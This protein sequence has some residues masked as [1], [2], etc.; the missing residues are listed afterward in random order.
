VSETS[1]QDA[2]TPPDIGRRTLTPFGYVLCVAVPILIAAIGITFLYFNYD[3]EDLVRGDRLQLLTSDW[4][5][6]DDAMQS[7]L[8]GELTLDEGCVR[9]VG[10]DGTPVDVVWPADFVA[11]VQEVGS[12]NQLKVYDPD[13]DIAARGGDRV[14]LGGGFESAEPYA[15]L[16]CGPVSDQVFLVQSEVVVSGGQ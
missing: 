9:L 13:R 12:E 10:E 8:T 6:G 7:A 14:L 4:K 5:P 1:P 16:A 2:P 15:G 11:T 3:K